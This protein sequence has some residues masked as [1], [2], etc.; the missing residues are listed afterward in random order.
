[1]RGW[2]ESGGLDAFGRAR[3][4]VE[5]LLASYRKPELD[6]AKVERLHVFVCDLAKKA[7]M[8]SLPAHELS[9]VTA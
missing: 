5:Q 4:R 6:P 8:D 7:G 9:P 3:I 1:V 2:K